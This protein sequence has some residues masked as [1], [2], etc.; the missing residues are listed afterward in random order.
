MRFAVFLYL[1]ALF[2]GIAFMALREF[3]PDI[4]VHRLR[5]HP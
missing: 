3:W 2:T 5:R 4:A 1:A